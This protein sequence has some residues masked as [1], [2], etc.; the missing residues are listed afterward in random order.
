MY[1]LYCY[2]TWW[3]KPP[4]ANWSPT[5]GPTHWLGDIICRYQPMTDKLCQDMYAV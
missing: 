1:I 3:L 5:N 4:D 2:L